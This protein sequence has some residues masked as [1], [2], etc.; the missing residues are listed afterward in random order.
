MIR[1][2]GMRRTAYAAALGILATAGAAVALLMF[3]PVASAWDWMGLPNGYSVADGNLGGGCHQIS[4]N[5]NLIGST[6][7]V[8]FQTALNAYVD[9]TICTVNPTAGGAA[10]ATTTTATTTQPATTTTV[11]VTGPPPATTTTVTQPVTTTVETT[12]QTVTV[13]AAA[14]TA[15]ASVVTVTTAIDLATALTLIQQRL[16]WLEFRVKALEDQVGLILGEE[17]NEPPFTNPA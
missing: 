10:C 9:A 2:L 4:V 11:V 1:R 14:P 13:P 7:D 3:A 8:G 16:D 17:K 6:C 5:G 15:T 12:T